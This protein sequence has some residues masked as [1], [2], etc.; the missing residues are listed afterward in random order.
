[1]ASTNYPGSLD[2]YPVPN[3]GDTISVADHWLG[4]AVIGI[5]TELGTDPAGTFT[6]VK[7]RLN[8]TDDKVI[9][10]IDQ[11]L[12]N[13]T[14]TASDNALMA[15]G[16]TAVRANVDSFTHKGTGLTYDSSTSIWTFPSTGYYKIDFH[17]LVLNNGSASPEIYIKFNGSFA[18]RAYANVNG[19]NASL[20]M[21]YIAKVTTSGSSGDTFS[22]WALTNY[23]GTIYV[24]G[25]NHMITTGFNCTRLG[26]I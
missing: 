6:D 21:S 5:E 22:F 17:C 23:S 8:D 2:A 19:R 1:M 13:S 11:W 18:A 12:I 7:S 24:S 3:N 26:D 25:D 14:Y 20:S 15:F 16:S 10:E 4:P 9:T